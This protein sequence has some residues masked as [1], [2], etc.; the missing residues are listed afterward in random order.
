MLMGHEGVLGKPAYPFLARCA[1]GRRL[2]PD[3]M[4]RI[5]CRERIRWQIIHVCHIDMCIGCG[6]STENVFDSMGLSEFYVC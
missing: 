6:I 5:K 4:I 2:G 3:W 1:D